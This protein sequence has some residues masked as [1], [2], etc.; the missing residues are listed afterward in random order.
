[1]EKFLNTTKNMIFL[2]QKDIFSSALILSLMIVISRIFGFM[3][4]RTLATFF[5]KE[6]LDLFFAAFR[7]PDFV[8]EIL[9]TGA[10]TSAFIPIFI[11]YE[12]DKSQL[13]ST[14]SSIINFMFVGLLIFVIVLFLSAD[15]II[16]L[17]TPGFGKEQI[18]L[19]VNL[20]RILL[21]AQLPLLIMGNILSGMA[22]ANRIF[23]V[24]AIAPILYNIGIIAGTIFFSPTV[25]I[26]GPLI[27][28]I[29]GAFIF[30]LVQTPT[31]FIIKF[32]YNITAFKKSVIGEFVKL[33]IP[34]LLSV[35]TTQIDLTIDL[36]LS[37]FLGSGSYT[38]FFFAQHLQLFPVSFIGMALG[39]ASLPYLSDLYAEKRFDEIRNIFVNSLLQILFLTVPISFIFMFA[40]TP[41]VRFFFGGEKFDWEGTVQTARTMSYFALSLPFHAIFYLLTRPFYAAHDTKTP[42]FINFFSVAVNTCLSLF[43]IFVLHLPVWSLAISFSIAIIC[44]VL[45][46]LIFFYRK[47]GGF[48]VRKLMFHAVKIYV[49]S[50]VA[51]MFSYP[52]MKLL[53]AVV[54]DTTRTINVFFLITITSMVY[55]MLYLFLSWLLDIE[56]I[57]LLGK[58]VT[59]MKEIKRKIVEVYTDVG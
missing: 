20:S 52:M 8:F 41:I 31:V 40:R 33:F 22:Q 11:K 51:F 50:L 28:T 26:Y 46:L 45:L 16:P 21:I 53:D 58:F 15:F 13:Y 6:E 2:R 1:M 48:L 59:K 29:L 32:H 55:S 42:F 23:I 39:Q 57:Y 36:I 4:Y 38:I 35:I 18:I 56:E 43:F 17:I 10:L 7:M 54:L 24:T 25:G 27:G 5:S 47:I 37:T 34:R 14:I 49:V 30:F 44:N 9:I 3:R 19:I 12:K